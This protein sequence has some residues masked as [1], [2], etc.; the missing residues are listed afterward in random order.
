MTLKVEKCIKLIAAVSNDNIIGLPDG[1]LPWLIPE[2]LKHF[3]DITTGNTIVMGSNT[4]RS[5]GSKP[6]PNRI[7]II[8]SRK[9]NY[10]PRNKYVK[11]IYNSVD[12]F[13]LPKHKQMGDIFIIGGGQIYSTYLPLVS[14]MYITKVDTY[15]GDGVKFASVNWNEWKLVESSNTQYSNNIGYSFK[16][17]V[18]T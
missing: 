1:S 5:I 9:D 18:R 6:L 10:L 4:W 17:Y 11:Q 3:K 14:E 16:K 13:N 8:L 2:D 7:N 15:I 12:I